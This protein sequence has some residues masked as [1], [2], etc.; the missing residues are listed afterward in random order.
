MISNRLTGDEIIRSNEFSRV[1]IGKTTG[2][3]AVDVKNDVIATIP[4]K[5]WIEVTFL[6]IIQDKV[7]KKGNISPKI[8]TGPLLIYNVIFFL[9]KVHIIDKLER[10]KE[11]FFLI[12]LILINPP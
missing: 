2:L 1:S 5:I 6:P 7:K 11:R 3:I 4:I 8:K 9:A 10:K 12:L